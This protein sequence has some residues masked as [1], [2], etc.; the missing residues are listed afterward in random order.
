MARLLKIIA[1]TAGILIALIVLAALVLPLIIDVNDHKDRISREIENA[2]GYEVVMEGDIEL[3]LIP[4][5]GLSL[6]KTT[7][8]NPPG[9]DDAPLAS[10]E[11]LQIRIK[12]WPVFLGRFEADR[13]ILNQFKLDLIKNAQG[14][15]NWII[16]QAP[17]DEPGQASSPGEEGEDQEFPLFL[18]EL[19]IDGLQVSNAALSYQD[20]Q[21]SQAVH[22]RDINFKTEK[23]S[24]DNPFQISGDLDF[25]NQDPE[26]Q[27]G[28]EFSAM[29]TLDTR[30]EE[31]RMD[32]FLLNIDA[33]GE[34]LA[35]P[36]E[37]ASIKS[38]ISYKLPNSSVQLNNLDISIYDARIQGSVLAANLDQT[39]DISFEING[40]DIDLDKFMADSSRNQNKTPSESKDSPASPKQDK[41]PA[42]PMSLSFLHDFSLDGQINIE[43]IQAGNILLD[44]LSAV[45]KS[46]QGKMVLSPVTV[47]LYSGVQTS[48][49][50]LEDIRDELHIN[51]VH[52]LKGLQL[53][54]FIN[55][56]TEKNIITGTAGIESDIKTRGLNN[57]E[58]TQNM[59]GSARFEVSDGVIKGI[60]LEKRIKEVF[61]LASGQISSLD[62]SQSG[63]ETSFTSMEASFDIN[64]GIAVSRDLSMKSPVLG[65]RGEM[66][67]DLPESHLDSKSQISIDGALREELASRYSLAD[68]TVPL[69]V[70]GPFNDL[71]FRLDAETII[72]SFVQEKG[73]SV[74][75]K[76]LDKTNS[77]KDDSKQNDNEPQDD[78]KDL[79]KKMIQ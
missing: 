25:E 77:S 73:E 54:P 61:A 66:T 31:I 19:N 55:D 10:L 34:A 56:V 72:K 45:V 69:K 38:D 42:Q 57:D 33:Q 24:L 65:L 28:F 47:K 64:N 21:T 44:S 40:R 27:S 22:L 46:G 39:P 70:S 52:N 30:T 15:Q 50:T 49:V 2:T 3:S 35:R 51:A 32:N 53:G 6:G 62:D 18:S 67:A 17:Q 7:V 23:I 74:L 71:S 75:R 1:L 41:S 76:L 13:I 11:E 68:V 37:N 14:D 63:G 16:S 8:A 20:R 5:I 59:S 78:V 48:D 26:L 9:F 4:W 29:T 60:N 79:L 36:V 58:F 12:F 43:K